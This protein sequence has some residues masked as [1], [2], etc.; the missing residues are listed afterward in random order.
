M[1]PLHM[2]PNLVH[3]LTRPPPCSV[4]REA[5]RIRPDQSW[6]KEEVRSC[7]MPTLLHARILCFLPPP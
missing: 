5:E 4:C 3:M 2:F 6:A 1:F 7:A